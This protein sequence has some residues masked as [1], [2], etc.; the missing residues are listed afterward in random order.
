VNPVVLSLILFGMWA[1]HAA[2]EGAPMPH[3]TLEPIRSL[4]LFLFRSEA[5][6]RAVFWLA[7]L[8]HVYEGFL[9]L[10]FAWKVRPGAIGFAMFWLVQTLLVGYPSL[11]LI[12]EQRRV[13]AKAARA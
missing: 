12:K 8:A 11:R 13:Q 10:R 5:V 4:G 2:S 7:V 3:S 6:L 1:C 9:G